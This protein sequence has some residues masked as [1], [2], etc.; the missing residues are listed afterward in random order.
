MLK[1]AAPAAVSL[2]QMERYNVDALYCQLPRIVACPGLLRR[3]IVRRNRR[4]NGGIALVVAACSVCGCAEPEPLPETAQAQAARATDGAAPQPPGSA[5]PAA[6]LVPTGSSDG[7]TVA[8]SGTVTP[9][10]NTNPM[11]PPG[12]PPFPAAGATQPPSGATPGAAVSAGA[13]SPTL[14]RQINLFGVASA[15]T[16]PEGSAMGF[17]LEYEFT[18][19]TPKP[20]VTYE[21]VVEP[22]QGQAWRRTVELAARG[23]LNTFVMEWPPAEGTYTTYLNEID[24]SGQR[25]LV[26]K[27]LKL[28]CAY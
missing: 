5:P 12:A 28:I 1:Q 8:P 23:N 7:S 18:S 24:T 6:S 15:Q 2:T 19:G 20:G 13:A 17:A 27:R 22:P 9:D 26:S 11:S 21:W 14:G 4:W 3:S 16:L 25:Q 10:G